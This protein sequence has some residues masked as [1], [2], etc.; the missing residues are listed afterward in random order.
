LAFGRTIPNGGTARAAS[1]AAAEE[2]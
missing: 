2:S 1:A